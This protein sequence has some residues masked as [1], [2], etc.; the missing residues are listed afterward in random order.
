MTAQMRAAHAARVVDLRERAFDRSPRRRIRRRPR[1]PRIRRRLRYTGA[2]AF[3]SSDQSRR[4]AVRLRDVRP[5]AHG[6]QVHH[7]LIAGRVEEKRGGLQ[8][9]R[10][11]RRAA[12][13]VVAFAEK[14]I[15]PFPLPAHRTGR[16]HFGHPALGRSAAS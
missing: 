7:R 14:S 16:D 8:D 10:R 6:V 5:N 13:F 15:A 2:C 4:P 9:R 11:L 1:G 12:S 3:G